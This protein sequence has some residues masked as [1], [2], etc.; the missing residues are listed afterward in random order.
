MLFS[1]IYL[2]LLFLNQNLGDG[3]KSPLHGGHGPG[4]S[5]LLTQCTNYM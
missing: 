3:E 4:V 1:A 5:I 2:F